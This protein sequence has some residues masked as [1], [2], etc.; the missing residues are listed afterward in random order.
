MATLLT[1]A[2]QIG[3]PLASAFIT[4]HKARALLVNTRRREA[5]FRNL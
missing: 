1:V 4:S 3:H 5:M 2:S